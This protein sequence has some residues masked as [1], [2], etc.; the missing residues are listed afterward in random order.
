[1]K[2]SFTVHYEAHWAELLRMKSWTLAVLGNQSAIGNWE[3]TKAVFMDTHNFDV[4]HTE[5]DASA[6]TYP[7]EYKYVVIDPVSK[8]IMEWENRPNRVLASPIEFENGKAQFVDD[9]LY[10]DLPL[11]LGAG[12][13]VPVFSLR[14]K[15]SFGVGDFADLKLLVDW[16]KRSGQQM[17]QILP[18]NDTTLQ[19]NKL[20]SY[21]YNTLSVF[22]LHPMYLRLEAIGKNDLKKDKSYIAL[23]KKLNALSAVDYEQVNEQKR[24]LLKSLY[25]AQKEETFGDKAYVQFLKKQAKWLVPYAA[26]SYLRDLEGTSDFSSWSEYAKYDEKAIHDLFHHKHHDISFYI[27]VQYHLHLQLA[28]AHAYAK[29]NG[30]LIKGDVPIGVSPQSVDVWCSPKLFNLNGQ[31]GAPPDAFSERGQNWGF[32]TY[33]WEEMAKDNYAWWKA[34]FAHMS[35]YFDAYR[36]DHILGFFRIWEVPTH[37]KWGLLGQFNKAYPLSLEEIESA[38]LQLDKTELTRVYISDNLLKLK[39]ADEAEKVKKTYLKANKDGSYAFKKEFD[40]QVKLAKYFEDSSHIDYPL[41]E[42]LMKLSCQVLFVPDANK[43]NHFHPRISYKQNAAYK[44]LTSGQEQVYEQLY[45]DYFYHRNNAL[46][47]E[48]AEL[49]LGELVRSTSM[50]CCGEDLGM[51]PDTVPQV[52]EDLHILSLEIQRMPKAYGLEFGFPAN[53][54]YLSVCTTSTHDMSPIREWWEEDKQKSQ[55]Y[56]NSILFEDGTA[57]LHCETWVAEKILWQHLQ[58]PAMW[59]I[60]PLQDWLAIDADLRHPDPFAERINVPDNPK[61][62]WQYRMHLNLEDLLKAEAFNEKIKGMIAGSRNG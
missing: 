42:R 19:N 31:A 51:I 41:F 26:F 7:M 37:A 62:L 2:L 45:E 22:A 57:P 1:M 52:M 35:I 59:V 34:R 55:R 36:I 48:Q 32:P 25:E 53:A 46:W 8:E 20:D 28:E 54:P 15:D 23:K 12:V 61:N 49:K 40:T 13:A 24:T 44:G 6:F 30:L 17:I 10:F 39:F 47:K 9:G 50:L 27:F 29:A 3:P 33:N 18:I 5:V 43:P 4:W 21:P 11:F 16:A 14:S 60:L 38:G 56:Y 58:S